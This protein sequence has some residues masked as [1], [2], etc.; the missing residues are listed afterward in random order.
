MKKKISIIAFVILVPIILGYIISTFFFQHT[1]I[2]GK[3]MLN[4][5]KDKDVIIIN[6]FIYKTESPKRYDVVLFKV[7]EDTYYVKRIIGM[8]GDKFQI[9]DGKIYVNGEIIEED[10]G[11]FDIEEPGIAKDEIKLGDDEYFVLGDNR[12]FSTD[13]RDESVGLVKKEDIVG[14]AVY[15]IYPLVSFGDINNDANL[16]VQQLEQSKQE[17][18][19][20]W[21]R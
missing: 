1:T 10:Y 13:S 19:D 18:Q 8:P 6:K 2:H 7:K 15:Q 3:S 21:K 5:F 20:E 12:A 4:T 16:K 17:N 9:V 11:L 14:K